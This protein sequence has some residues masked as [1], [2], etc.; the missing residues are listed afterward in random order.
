MKVQ[1]PDFNIVGFNS[2][3]LVGIMEE[4]WKKIVIDNKETVYSV[5]NTG[6]VR[7]DLYMRVLDGTVSNNGY[8]MVHLHCR[9]DKV[10]SVHRLVMKAFCPC[11]CMDDLQINHKDGNKANNNLNNLEWAT[12]LENIRHSFY[13]N[14]QKNKMLHCCVYDL[15]GNFIAEYESANDASKYIGIH[16]STINRCLNGQYGHAGK[17]Q[18][19][20]YKKDKI[21]AW[22]D[23]KNKPVYVYDL[24]GRFLHRYESIKQCGEQMGISPKNISRYILG[25]RKSS[26]F[27]FSNRL[28]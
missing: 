4:L 15:D 10:C 18:F 17:Y 19:R 25:Q 13:T 21:S 9:I 2:E 8:I 27:I 11:D 1:R 7:N 20:Q 14:L 26:T 22:N 12:A 23:P 3:V 28:L 16:Q 24:D 5:S 6:K